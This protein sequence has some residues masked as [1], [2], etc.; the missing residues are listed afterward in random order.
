[1]RLAA[2]LIKVNKMKAVYEL[3]DRIIKKEDCLYEV[4][5]PK[6]MK[7][8]SFYQQGLLTKNDSTYDLSGYYGICIV[9]SLKQAA[10]I[11]VT[12]DIV[13]NQS[14][15]E[16][17]HVAYERSIYVTQGENKCITIPVESFSLQT[18][19]TYHLR[20][21]R[22]IEIAADAPV[23]IKEVMLKKGKTIAVSCD[24]LSKAANVNETIQYKVLLSNCTKEVQM[25]S[26]MEKKY[27]WQELALEYPLRVT[28][29]P[30]EEKEITVCVT[31]SEKIGMGGQEEQVLNFIPNGQGEFAESVTFTTLRALTH[32]FVL[33]DKKELQ[34]VRERIEAGDWEKE[35]YAYWYSIADTWKAPDMP[36]NTECLFQSE[37]AQYLRVTAIMYQICNEKRFGL[38]VVKFLKE[39]SDPINGYFR[40]YHAGHQELVH[41]GEV[42]KD[43][44]IAYDLV[45]DMEELTQENHQ[46]LKNVFFSVMQLF[47]GELRKAQISNWTLAEICGGLYMAC[48]LQDFHWIDRF[49]YGVGGAAEHLSKG[50]FAGGWW[51]E[52][53]IGYNLLCAG[54][55]SE[56][57][58]VVSHFGIDFKNIQ[59]SANYANSVNSSESLKDGLVHEN[60]GENDKSYRNIRMLWDS[61]LAYTDYRGVLF[62]INDSIEMKLTGIAKTLSPRYDLAYYLYGNQEYA[63]ILS[64]LDPKERDLLFGM[65]KLIEETQ[66]TD[67]LI[68]SYSDN[69]GVAVLRSRKKGRLAREQI[70]VGIKYGSHGGAHGHY[71][72]V[73]MT[74]VMRY[75]RSLTNPENIWYSYHTFMYKFYVQ[76]SINHNMVTVDLKLQDPKEPKRLLFY[77]GERMQAIAVENNSRW[78][79]PPYGG[80]QVNED[81]TFAERTWNEGR[82]VPIPDYPPEYEKRTEFTEPVTTRRVTVVT[83][84]FIVNF[85]YAKGEER[86]DYDCLYHLHGLYETNGLKWQGYTEQLDESP[87][88]SGQFITDCDWYTME[89]GGKLRFQIKYGETRNNGSLWLCRNRTG[90]N[91]TGVLK[92]DLYLAYPKEANVIVGCDPEYQGVNK[93]LFYEVLADGESLAKGKFGAWILGKE[94]IHVDISQKKEL[95]LKVKVKQVEFEKNSYMPMEKSVFWGNPYI[96]KE[97]GEKVFLAELDM[98]YI[99]IDTGNGV[100]IDYAKGPVKIQGELFEKAIPT[101]P[102]DNTKEG[103]IRVDLSKVDAKYFSGCIGS[104]YPVGDE[105]ERRR[106]VALR[107]TGTQAQFITVLEPVENTHLIKK[108]EALDSSHLMVYLEDKKVEII[109]TGMESKMPTVQIKEWDKEKLV[110]YENA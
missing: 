23:E 27:G 1:M 40:T 30:Y 60:W 56:I 50:T 64:G 84:D 39:M 15:K 87:L 47:D 91:E 44:A 37:Q 104:D 90:Y 67:T 28:L 88:S 7:D 42:F 106:T 78:S 79:N 93:Q 62:G 61:L 83:D 43:I 6:S 110:A 32:P 109:V 66:E 99:N 95:L 31:M 19:E 36:L 102:Q 57:A 10:K 92:T 81:K 59:V 26:L 82:F 96:E 58:Q 69:A 35:T 68:S 85:D 18:A 13:K 107:T 33:V 22:G 86:H 94:Q 3:T 11:T 105:T 100:G 51:F 14:P 97:N 16:E 4:V 101:E 38:E 48:V 75:G 55:F 49:L 65:A 8:N 9:L 89:E 72:R 108:V 34:G 54:L 46:N 73:S 76:N 25:I 70:Q 77:S 80:W 20:F 24:C 103:I 41:E 12:L 74:N 53:S 5:Y 45:H 63:K 52:V 29:K 98:E 2:Y 21:V 71:D 17:K